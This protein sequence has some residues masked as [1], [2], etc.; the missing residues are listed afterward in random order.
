MSSKSNDVNDDD[1]K[2]EKIGVKRAR[3]FDFMEMFE[4]SVRS[5][6]ERRPANSS[7][8]IL[9]SDE[10]A[11]L[12]IKQDNFLPPWPVSDKLKKTFGAPSKV[13][14]KKSVVEDDDEIIGPPVPES[15]RVGSAS[16]DEEKASDGEEKGEDDTNEDYDDEEE[17]DDDDDDTN[18]LRRLPSNE[19]VCLPRFHC[20]L[21]LASWFHSD[22]LS[23]GLV[24]SEYQ[25]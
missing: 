9:P 16:T 17:E 3:Q 5:A 22:Y 18:P 2:G 24:K 25:K 21:V 10:V 11:A 13:T 7:E 15:L 12:S 23:N 1:K 4:T 19:Q 8:D 14:V 20:R 6:V